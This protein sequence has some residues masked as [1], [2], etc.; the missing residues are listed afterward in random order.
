M[1]QFGINVSILLREYPFLER[2]DQAARLGFGVAEFWWPHGEDLRALARRAR[3]AGVRVALINFDGGDLAAGERGLLNDPARLPAFR[4]HVPAAL[5]LAA[6]L[7]CPRMNA[8]AGKWRANAPRDEQLAHLREQYAWLAAQAQPAGVAVQ[9]EPLN[10][11]D[12]GPCVF[13]RS[14][15]TLAFIESVGAPNL[16][17]QYDIY[18][19]QRMEGNIAATV[20]ELGARF[21]HMQLADS[22][23][24]HQPG[25]GE[26]RFGYLFEAIAASG[27]T[28]V[29]SAEYNP[30]GGSA[31][32]LGWLP[33]DRR[34]PIAPSAL[35]L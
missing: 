8:L 21:G 13:T 17:L 22:P 32:S 19:M 14:R 5:E 18:H 27:Y 16:Q 3:D 7:G 29:I 9:I 6:Q 20:R 33:P 1:L 30:L 35:S 15:E 24:R 12:N 23:G 28:G 2:F 11:W 10:R 34:G 25:T 26:L 31:A 4:A